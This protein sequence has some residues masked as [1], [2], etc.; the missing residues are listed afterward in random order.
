[1]QK[2]KREFYAEKFKRDFF[3]LKF[4]FGHL[5]EKHPK[6]FFYT[7]LAYEDAPNEKSGFQDLKYPFFTLQ[8]PI[9]NVGLKSPKI[10]YA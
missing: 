8:F 9:K 6:V 4:P 7:N 1:M 3:N 2:I 5:L 10:A